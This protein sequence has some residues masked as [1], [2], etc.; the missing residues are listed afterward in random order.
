M[1]GQ[2][3]LAAVARAADGRGPRTE[4]VAATC[5]HCGVERAEDLLGCVQRLMCL[6]TQL[7]VVYNWCHCTVALPSMH[8]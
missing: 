6:R 3:A 7:L 2:R 1:A 8:M 5:R 4:L